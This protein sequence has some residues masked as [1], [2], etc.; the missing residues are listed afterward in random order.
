S[1]PEDNAGEIFSYL[2][3]VCGTFPLED[4]TYLL[5]FTTY[6][7]YTVEAAWFLHKSQSADRDRLIRS[8]QAVHG[9]PKRPGND[10]E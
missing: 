5:E 8:F 4:K 1:Q 9:F 7:S 6:N 10:P 3:R 2:A